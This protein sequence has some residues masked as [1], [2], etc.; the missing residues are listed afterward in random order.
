MWS[1]STLSLVVCLALAFQLLPAVV[2]PDADSASQDVPRLSLGSL[3]AG[4]C[5]VLLC[6][7][8]VTSQRQQKEGGIVDY[9]TVIFHA[10]SGVPKLLLDQSMLRL[11]AGECQIL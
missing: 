11:A 2:L 9:D 6:L 7:L 4:T 8:V 10:P 3:V 5:G 1:S